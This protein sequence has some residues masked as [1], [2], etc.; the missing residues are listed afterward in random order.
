MRI[1][2]GGAAALNIGDVNASSLTLSRTTIVTVLNDD[3]RVIGNDIQDS[4]SNARITF[5]TGYTDFNDDIELSGND[6]RDSSGTNR[7]SFST[8]GATGLTALTGFASVSQDFESAGKI[9]GA[10]VLQIGGADPVAYSRFGTGTTSESH[11]ISSANDL[12]ISGDLEVD[13]SVSF[14]GPASISNTLY[15]STLGNTGNV[16]IGTTV[17]GYLFDARKNSASSVMNTVASLF[18]IN[19]GG[20]GANNIGSRIE[21]GGETTTEGTADVAAA[22]GG[23]LTTATAGAVDGE[24]AFYT[25]TGGASFVEQM[26]IDKNGNVGIGSTVPFRF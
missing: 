10:G 13:G 12:L 22:I 17:P 4:A 1:D 14:A 15:I 16:G 26:R 23:L 6:I 5:A 9:I 21:F 2:A 8:T 24:L 18:Q 11:Y 3:L 7:I 19:S 25:R 20:A